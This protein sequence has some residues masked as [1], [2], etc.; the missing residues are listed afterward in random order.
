VKL[1]SEGSVG[2]TRVRIR[3]VSPA[4]GAVGNQVTPGRFEGGVGLTVFAGCLNDPADT[5]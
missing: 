3:Y 4:G 1:T 2:K 5:A